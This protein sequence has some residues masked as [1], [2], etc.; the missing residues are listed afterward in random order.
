MGSAMIRCELG[1]GNG[2]FPASLVIVSG[3]L[4]GQRKSK[5][6]EKG[7]EREERSLHTEGGAGVNLSL[8]V[9]SNQGGGDHAGGEEKEVKVAEEEHH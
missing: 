6:T 7:D 1:G 9:G 5:K 4:T 2:L 3:L 8:S